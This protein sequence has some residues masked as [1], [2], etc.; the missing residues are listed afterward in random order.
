MDL[1]REMRVAMVELMGTGYTPDYYEQLAGPFIQ[2][3]KAYAEQ[4]VAMA[5]GDRRL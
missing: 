1:E 3:A 2:I 4:Q 5:I